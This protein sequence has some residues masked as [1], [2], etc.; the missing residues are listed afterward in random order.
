MTN[1][2]KEILEGEILRPGET[3][4]QQEETISIK[5]LQFG[6]FARLLMAMATLAIIGLGLFLSFWIIIFSLPIIAGIMIWSWLKR[7]S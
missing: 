6:W 4:R 1:D 5:T 2:D 3:Y 7:L